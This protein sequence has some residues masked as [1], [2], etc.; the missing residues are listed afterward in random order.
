MQ[1]GKFG[2]LVTNLA[3]L[4]SVAAC[5]GGGGDAPASGGTGGTGISFGTVTDFGSIILNNSRVDDSTASVT[6]DDNPG[7]GPNGGLKKGMVV[8]V[9]GTFSGSTGTATTIEYKDNLEGP[10]CSQ[11]TTDGITT[12]RVLGQTVIRDAATIVESGPINPGNIVEVSGLPDNLGNIRATFIENKTASGTATAI[13]V[14]GRI[15]SVSA[16][17]FTINGLVV[18]FAGASIDNNI[19]GGQPATGQFVEVKGTV[20]ACDSPAPGTD[21]L[22]ATRVELEVEGAGNV[23]AGNRA[24]IEGII[25]SANAG[26]FTVG[27]QQFVTTAGT[28][29]L[30]EDF[31]AGDLQVGAKVEV[32][33]TVSNGLLTATKVSFRQ[34]V[35]LESTVQTV[36]GVA[37]TLAITL[38][39]LPGIVISTDSSTEINDPV[40]Q[41]AHMRVRGIEG[42]GNTVLA[43]RI[44]EQGGSTVFLQGAVDDVANPNITV[45]GITVDTTPINQFE[46]VN[47]APL[48]RGAF[49]SRVQRGTLV[50][51]KGD[52][53]G[54][55]PT[56]DEAELED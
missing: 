45:L 24:E 7:A 32:E 21:A 12:L 2:K 53:T 38:V 29:F 42:P 3:I 9:S 19:P 8:K 34:N 41:G 6:L 51:I 39:G 27:N 5:G 40:V 22:T 20:F 55:T 56:W 50:K 31:G 48:E 52:L 36:T 33:G 10:V 17:T 43:T 13:E 28:R 14:K 25:T 49:F 54:V 1:F 46:D 23:P 30:P 26:T 11:S 35:K 4:L 44:D 37:P 18:N 47:D 16:P 15:D